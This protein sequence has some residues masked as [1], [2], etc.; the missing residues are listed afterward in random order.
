MNS[1]KSSAWLRKP[2]E[3]RTINTNSIK[4]NIEALQN[5]RQLLKPQTPHSIMNFK[6]C[7]D[8]T[9]LKVSLNAGNCS[10]CGSIIVSNRS[11]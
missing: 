9:I 1:S 2:L 10:S 6:C 3:E 4:I 8:G 5:L 11:G 7:S